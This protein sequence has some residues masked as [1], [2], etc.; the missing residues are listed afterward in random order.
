MGFLDDLGKAA[1]AP[2]GMAMV[3]LPGLMGFAGAQKDQVSQESLNRS[4][5]DLVGNTE[6]GKYA[7]EDIFKQYQ[8]LNDLVGKGPGESDVTA[9]LD[10]TRGLA[11]MLD[12]YRST[13]G[14]P[15]ESDMNTARNYSNDIFA[16]Q[17]TAL[18]QGFEQ[19]NIQ[20]NRLAAQLGRPVNDPILRAKLA[21][22]Q[23][24]Q[25]Q[26]LESQKRGFTSEF[27]Q[28]LPMQR[29]GFTA[30]L[31]DVRN[32]LASQAMANRQALLGVGQSIQTNER[33]FRLQQ[34]NRWQTGKNTQESGG[35]LSGAIGGFMSGVGMLGSIAGMGGGGG[36]FSSMFGGGGGQ[37]KPQAQMM[38]SSGMLGVDTSMGMG[39]P[40]QQQP[41]YLMGGPSNFSSRLNTPRA[42]A[43]MFNYSSGALNMSG[44]GGR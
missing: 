2:V 37:S 19:Q 28:N 12:L 25:Q 8:G 23:I 36:G 20:A 9:G 22:D 44:L 40:M 7:D 10:S 4:G 16:A 41:S 21:Q 34:S 1:L 14:L 35:G 6:A 15:N 27:A 17:Q 42:S 5:I 38:G 3:G 39:M 43:P 26:M 29:L 24:K 11:S 30:Q 32:S 13:G 31:A 18:D 33:N